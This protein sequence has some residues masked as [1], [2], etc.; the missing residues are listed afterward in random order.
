M[1]IR[2]VR[3]FWVENNTK[4][5]V[6]NNELD[7]RIYIRNQGESELVLSIKGRR[8][9]DGKTLRLRVYDHEQ[10]EPLLMIERER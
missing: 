2:R 3:D 8:L 4:T 9:Y 10:D 6:S 7:V 5:R 1:G